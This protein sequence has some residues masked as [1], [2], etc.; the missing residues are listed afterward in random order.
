MNEVINKIKWHASVLAPLLLVFGSDAQADGG[1]FFDD[2]ASNDG[3]GI[4]YR[5]TPSANNAI[6]D[7]MKAQGFLTLEQGVMI[8]ANSRGAPGVAVF[9]F[10]NDGDEDIYV[11]NGPGTP[12]SLYV[13]QSANGG[14]VRFVDMGVSAGV[15]A[16]DQ[17]ST[18]VCYGDIDNDGD[19]DL[20]VVGNGGNARLFS[21]QGD[22]SFADITLLSGVD[23]NNLHSSSCSMGDVNNDGLLDIAIANTFDNWDNRLPLMTFEY[24]HL[25]EHNLLFLN[26]GN[27]NFED[28]SGTSGIQTIARISWALALVD[29]DQDGDADLIV[30]DD[31]GPRAP[32]KYGGQDFGYIRVYNNDGGG[33]FTELTADLGLE[34]FGA[35][36]GL[37]FG[38]INHDGSLD[39]FATNIGDYASVF[40]APLFGFAPI[41]GEWASIWFFGDHNGGLTKGAAGE[42]KT[43]AFGWGVSMPDYDNDGDIDII[44]HGG[45]DVGM[46]FDASNPGVV[47][48]NDGDGNFRLDAESIRRSSNHSRRTVRGV[49]IGD[50]DGNGFSDVVSVSNQDWPEPYPLAPYLPVSLGG[51]LDDKTFIWPTFSPIDPMDPTQGF[52][53]TG[54]EPTDGT[55]SVE[56][57]DGANGNHW[58]KVRVTGSVGLTSTAIVNRDGIGAVISFTPRHG[59]TST[60]P[61]IGGASYASQDSLVSIFGL[62]RKKR[63]MV[64][65]MWPGGVKNRLYNVRAYETV[66]FP[67][68]PCSFDDKNMSR[69]DYLHCVRTSLKD[70]RRAGAVDRSHAIRLFASA[71]RAYHE[72]HQYKTNADSDHGR[73]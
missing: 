46:F 27:S 17:D 73:I 29:Y 39:M 60:R 59:E 22:G 67:E 55:L 68:I 63:G 38:D 61:V 9:D 49:A 3:A 66:V 1:V 45:L 4:S 71:K 34:Q 48:T 14:G 64:E 21:N 52:V 42:M 62:G 72:T 30:A 6:W 7:A 24:E 20:L 28:I 56:L 37:A 19:K 18:G 44:Y 26:N 23:T 33:Q 40:T 50:L 25:M 32:A 16:T 15:A 12:N 41:V 69:R 36:M 5:R 11:T 8:P 47:L 31:Q 57:N 10:D 54:L 65:V 53:W 70:L 58:A 2:I 13:N 43:T 51:S 35:W